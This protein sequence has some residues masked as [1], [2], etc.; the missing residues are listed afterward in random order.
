VR[1]RAVP[2][3]PLDG[4]AREVWHGLA[5]PRPLAAR[6]LARSTGLSERHLLRRC[7]AAFGYGPARLTRILRIQ[8]L[9]HLART[10][11]GAV[12]L[13]DLAATAGYVDQQHL[14]HEVRAVFDTTPTALLRP[15]VRS[16][17][18]RSGPGVG[19]IEA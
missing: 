6:R 5:R 4:V 11:P 1:S 17:Q 16:V 14:T 8:R 15:R 19:R 13:A 7:R 9:L 3:R 12:R 18:D 2:S 10:Q